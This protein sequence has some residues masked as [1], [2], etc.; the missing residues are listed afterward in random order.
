MHAIIR[1]FLNVQVLSYV[2]FGVLTTLVDW[3]VYA[4]LWSLGMDYRLSTA[5]SWFA[6]VIFAF[7]TN[8]LFVFQSFSVKLVHL[9]NEFIAFFSC[10]AVTGIM[11]LVLMM[12]M[13][14]MLHLHEFVGKFFTSAISLVLN[15]L[16]S[17]LFV[18]KKPKNSGR[19]L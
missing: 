9:W 18:F 2:I 4:W 5:I 6:A 15:Y 14:D 10:R 12:L 1:K 3:G 17:K 16:F 13:V 19:S 11:T 8:K 7:I